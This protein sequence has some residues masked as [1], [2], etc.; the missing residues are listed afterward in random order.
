MF[1]SY[2]EACFRERLLWGSPL[3]TPV[4]DPI[5]KAEL[6]LSIQPAV[7]ASLAAGLQAPPG[8]SRKIFF[9]GSCSLQPSCKPSLLGGRDTA[10]FNSRPGPG[11]HP[12]QLCLVQFWGII[13]DRAKFL[14]EFRYLAEKPFYL[15]YGHN[16]TLLYA[17]N[18]KDYER[19]RDQFKKEELPFHTYTQKK[20]KTHAFVVRKA[21]DYDPRFRK[22]Y[23]RPRHQPLDAFCQN[24]PPGTHR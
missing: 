18:E 4:V 1:S 5:K 19:L 3:T 23:K 22:R 2:K 13:A 16:S 12:K 24:P 20:N 21:M 8:N 15:K 7:Q 9:G 17:D 10:G 11:L 14:R 6:I